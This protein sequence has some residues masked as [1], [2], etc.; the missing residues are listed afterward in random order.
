MKIYHLNISIAD[1]S[2]GSLA[3]SYILTRFELFDLPDHGNRK[4][5]CR[6]DRLMPNK[7]AS[8]VV[9]GQ[10]TNMFLGY[11]ST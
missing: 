5:F 10:T 6:I 9:V 2:D 3:D 7:Q 11:L 8:K 4:I 1:V